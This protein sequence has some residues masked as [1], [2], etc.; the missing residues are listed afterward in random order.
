MEL[1][2]TVYMSKSM[3]L[4]FLPVNALVEETVVF[5]EFGEFRATIAASRSR[6][7]FIQRNQGS[8]NSSKKDERKATNETYEKS[9]KKLSHIFHFRVNL[10]IQLLF[11]YQKLVIVGKIVANALLD[12][13]RYLKCRWQ[14]FILFYSIIHLINIDDF[15]NAS[16][17]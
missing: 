8:C 2:L 4:G 3:A 12:M 13:L 5:A 9:Y 6:Y 11:H 14:T 15:D 7:L 1:F 16:T 10:S 17:N